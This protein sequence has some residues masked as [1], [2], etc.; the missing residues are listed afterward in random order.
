MGDI[1]LDPFGKGLL[2][3][4]KPFRR[5]WDFNITIQLIAPFMEFAGRI[6]ARSVF[7]ANRG[8]TSILGTS[9]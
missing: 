9:F 2:D 4:G 8:S 3:G 5:A 6:Q 1:N 7:L